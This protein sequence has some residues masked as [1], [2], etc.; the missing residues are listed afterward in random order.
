[1]ARG[2]MSQN[3]AARPH[4]FGTVRGFRAPALNAMSRVVKDQWISPEEL[5]AAVESLYS[6]GICP[7]SRILKRRLVERSGGGLR[8]VDIDTE[9]LRAAVAATPELCV[10]DGDA[11]DWT[12]LLRNRALNV[13]D[14]HDPDDMYGPAF[15]EA[16]A[17]YI[18]S[19]E[20]PYEYRLPSSRYACACELQGRELQ[21]LAGL[22]LGRI[23]HVVQLAISKKN[24]LGYS[25]GALVPYAMSRCLIKKQH[26]EYGLPC[27]M[28]SAERTLPCADWGTMR[29]CLMEIM[30]EAYHSEE[31]VERLAN[32]KR[33]FRSRY[34][35]DLSETLLGHTKLSELLQDPRLADLCS[36]E[37]WNGSYAVV[38][39]TSSNGPSPICCGP[40]SPFGAL[41]LQ[42][43][44]SSPQAHPELPETAPVQPPPWQLSPS[45]L[46]KNGSI[47]KVPGG[48]LVKN[49]F[50]DV[51]TATPAA[52][53]RLRARS[54]PKDF[55]S[56]KNEWEAACHM[57]SYQYDPVNSQ[58]THIVVVEKG[59]DGLGLDVSRSGDTLLV[60]GI[61]PGAI[62]CWNAQ[63]A[64]RPVMPGDHILEVNG[65]SG[66]TVLLLQAIRASSTLTLTVR[67]SVL[68]RRKRSEPNVATS[69]APTPGHLSWPMDPYQMPSFDVKA[70]NAFAM[71]VVEHQSLPHTAAGYH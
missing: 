44:P 60:E 34:H 37:L 66:D 14:V 20:N 52:G 30:T 22:T 54:V 15:W 21:F 68:P 39:K 40:E 13:V 61:G 7:Y 1:M 16:F 2:L 11:S 36:V 56:K 9:A 8:T 10:G 48:T 69:L 17:D 42:F 3:A 23:C 38:P 5:V 67:S 27:A 24:I 26:A 18:N 28:Q 49:T 31:G 51:P 53:A 57:L 46:R 6:D 19:L 45:S 55:G 70:M 12:A 59:G 71:P 65:V 58:P 43:A 50:I 41:H 33:I 63:H 35:L 4:G 62:Q 32:I 29:N 64:E 25:N 47:T